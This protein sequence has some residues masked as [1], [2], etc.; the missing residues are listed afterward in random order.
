M[1]TLDIKTTIASLINDY[2]YT[3]TVIDPCPVSDLNPVTMPDL[4]N[5]IRLDP[6]VLSAAF[7]EVRAAV[8]I[9]SPLDPKPALDCCGVMKYE[10]NPSTETQVVTLD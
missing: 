2:T 3:Q 10:L 4:T 6:L 8:C 1:Y 7:D 9:D 5:T